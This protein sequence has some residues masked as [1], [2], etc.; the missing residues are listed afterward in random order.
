MSDNNW[1]NFVLIPTLTL[2]SI[3]IILIII[4]PN[5]VLLILFNLK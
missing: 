5:N 2:L 3:I 1:K 4:L